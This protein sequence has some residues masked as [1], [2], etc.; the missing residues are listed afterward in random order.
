MTFRQTNFHF[1]VM[2][3]MPAFWRADRC[4]SPKRASEQIPV[5]DRHQALD[6]GHPLG[7]GA[8]QDPR[9]AVFDAADDHFAGDLRR[10]PQERLGPLASFRDLLLGDALRHPGVDILVNNAGVAL[11]GA[12]EQVADADF[13]W[14]F[15]I[16]FWGVVRMTRAFLPLLHKS[17]EARIVNISSV[18]A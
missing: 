18:S 9:P 7:V 12:F 16:N 1:P 4:S 2:P 14:L 8:D 10:Q 5:S 13:D 15:A 11:G 3:G 6:D 17:E